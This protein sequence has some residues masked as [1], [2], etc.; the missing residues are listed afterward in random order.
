MTNEELRQYVREQLSDCQDVHHIDVLIY[1]DEQ[2]YKANSDDHDAM[3][4][5]LR[6][7]KALEHVAPGRV[8]AAYIY[9]EDERSGC[10]GL[11]STE[12]IYLPGGEQ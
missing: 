12:D 8:F 7:D 10:V 2:D 5:F 1:K 9:R 3:F 11:E 4:D 6:L